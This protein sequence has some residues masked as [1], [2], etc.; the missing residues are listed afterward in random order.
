M[1]NFPTALEQAL[2]E[3]CSSAWISS[4]DLS[5]WFRRAPP[6]QSSEVPVMVLVDC[7]R[8]IAALP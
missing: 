1:L 4:D 3:A 6:P 2:E 7:I 8:T 5:T